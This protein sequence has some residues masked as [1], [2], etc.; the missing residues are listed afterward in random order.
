MSKVD[1]GTETNDKTRL[2]YGIG[3]ARDL[4][5][6]LDLEPENSQLGVSHVSPTTFARPT[7]HLLIVSIALPN[8]RPEQ[9]KL[10]PPMTKVFRRT[11]G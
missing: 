9:G 6:L 2:R 8:I 5:V 11:Q 3:T 4:H 10:Q 1:K 7:L